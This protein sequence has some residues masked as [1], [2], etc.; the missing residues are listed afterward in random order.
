M[1]DYPE[2]GVYL[3]KI[4]L[5]EQKSIKVGALGEQTFAAGYYFYSGTAQRNLKARIER[6]YSSDK[7]LHWHIDYLL[8]EAELIKDYFFEL[9]R[10]GECFLTQ[11]LKD[12]GGRVIVKGF[13]ASDCSCK[14]HLL[15]FS[16]A[17]V[18]GIIDL[19]TEKQN[20]EKE[21]NQFL[22]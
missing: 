8:A 5:N 6:H 21:F 12:Q 4:K 13:G 15:Y 11:N 19:I 17:E 16:A 20:L 22:K 7:K 3:L 2:S 1:K 10:E 18:E 14:S 9:P